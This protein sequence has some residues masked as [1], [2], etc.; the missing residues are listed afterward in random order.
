MSKSI[1]KCKVFRFIA[2]SKKI[3]QI[4]PNTNRKTNRK[5]NIHTLK[6]CV[7]NSVKLINAQK[8]IVHVDYLFMH[9]VAKLGTSTND[10]NILHQDLL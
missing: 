3:Q 8:Y 9:T 5:N 6:C 1:H 4:Y 2:Q 10:K 7:D